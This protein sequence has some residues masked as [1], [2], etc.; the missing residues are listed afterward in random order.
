MA[1]SETVTIRRLGARGDGI[2]DDG[3]AIA[4]A[5]PGERVAIRRDGARASTAQGVTGRTG[6]SGRRAARI[7]AGAGLPPS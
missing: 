3:T 7:V 2:A 5:L 1:E 6:G 4:F